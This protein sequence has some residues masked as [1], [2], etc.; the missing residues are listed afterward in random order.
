PVLLRPP[1]RHRPP[2]GSGGLGSN[3]FPEEGRFAHKGIHE[4][5]LLRKAFRG[6]TGRLGRTPAIPPDQHWR[7][8]MT[9]SNRRDC[10]SEITNAIVSDLEKGIRPWATPWRSGAGPPCR[11]LR[12]NGVPYRGINVLWLWRAAELAGYRSN[13]W[14]TYN[15]ARELGGQ[16]RKGEKGS[17]VVYANLYTKTDD[18]DD[19]EPEA[20][21][22]PFL[23]AY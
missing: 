20:K 5:P 11:P 1:H 8:A 4:P 12:N 22:I 23:K 14:F 10:Y 19:R 15:Q 3:S 6:N 16:V 2:G 21:R 17:L 7:E 9:T 18:D 13:F